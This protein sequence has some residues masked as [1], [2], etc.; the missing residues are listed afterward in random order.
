M[1]A[2]VSRSSAAAIRRCRRRDQYPPARRCRRERGRSQFQRAR[3]CGRRLPLC[4]RGGR[5]EPSCFPDGGRIICTYF[6]ALPGPARQFVPPQCGPSVA[7]M[8]MKVLLHVLAADLH[9]FEFAT[10]YGATRAR[11]GRVPAVAWISASGGRPNPW[12]DAHHPGRIRFDH[13]CE[14]APSFRH[15]ATT[16]ACRWGIQPHSR[17]IRFQ[18]NDGQ[19]RALP[20]HVHNP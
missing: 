1:P 5:S 4:R 3:T 17:P 11:N 12:R 6:S 15:A 9:N 8:G 7:T 19:R 20:M 2:G 10:R 16:P 13:G 14:G 18:G